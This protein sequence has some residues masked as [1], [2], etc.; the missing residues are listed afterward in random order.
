MVP[1]PRNPD[2][3]HIVGV[4]MNQRQFDKA[5]IRVESVIRKEK[6]QEAEEVL[7][8]MC[9]LLHARIQLIS[10]EKTCPEDLIES[11]HTIIWASPRTQIEELRVIRQ[12]LISKV[13]VLRGRGCG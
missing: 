8:L 13:C 5:R 2:I 10:Q 12:Q 3:S 7:E 11:V 4:Q 1:P 6:E 9:E